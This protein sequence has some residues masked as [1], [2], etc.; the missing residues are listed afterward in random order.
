MKNVKFNSFIVLIVSGFFIYYSLRDNFSQSMNLLVSSKIV[1]ILAAIALFLI[2]VVFESYA[3]YLVSREQK[4]GYPFWKMYR[5]QIM[6]KFFNGITPFAAGG[7]PLQVYELHKEGLTYV[8]ATSII[9]QNFILF[10]T[11]IVSLGII[12]IIANFFFDFFI[13]N[14]VM[15]YF[16]IVGFVINFLLLIIVVSISVNEKRSKKIV[17]WLIKVFSKLKITNITEK[18]KKKAND[19]IEDY[20]KAYEKLKNNKKLF[21]KIV[22]IIACSKIT[23]FLIPQCI[24][25][26]LRI[27]H[28]LSPLVTIVTG[29]YIFIMSSFVPIP[30]GTGGAEFGF[31]AFFSNFVALELIPP[32]LILWRFI[33][34]Y[35]PTLIG[36]IVYNFFGENKELVR[37]SK[38]QFKK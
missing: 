12:S 1:W 29:V 33:T 31:L 26:A 32:A 22:L 30:G 24:F 10:Q 8:Q 14:K 27:E 17:N 18:R 7:Q 16:V 2:Y 23:L 38:K 37:K 5:L 34:Y 9:V 15:R 19:F 21:L 28:T 3:I 11:A 20:T 25:N 13:Y 4:K 36:G 6:T 35:A